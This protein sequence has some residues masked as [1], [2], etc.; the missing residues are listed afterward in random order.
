MANFDKPHIDISDR[1]KTRNYQA[2]RENRGGGSAPRIREQHGARLQQQLAAAYQAAQNATPN[3]TGIEVSGVLIEVELQ[4]GAK[5]DLLDRKSDGIRAGAVHSDGQ[6]ASTIGLLVPEGAKAV[7]E[8]ILQDYRSGPLTP[9]R[10]IPQADK[11]EPIEAIRQAR[12]ETFWTDELSALPQNPQDQ[13]WWEVWCIK[14]KQEDVRSA[15]ARLG[16]HV[17]DQEQWLTFPEAIVIPI[18]ATRAAIELLLFASL[19]VTELRR[20]S[21]TPAFFL[22]EN[23]EEQLDWSQDFADRITWPDGNAPAV[24]LLDTGVNRGH[25]LIEPA[26]AV[27]DLAAV[28]AEWGT[29][30]DRRGHGTGMAGLALHSDLVSALSDGRTVQLTH[31]L[32]SVKILP[33]N[34]FDPTDP[35]NYGTITQTAT[36][37][38]ELLAPE[39]KRVFC[40]SVTN[41]DVSGSRATTWSAAIDQAAV[42]KMIGDDEDAPRRLFVV[43]AGNTIPHLERHRIQDA[44]DSPIEDPAQAWNALT[45]G[46]Y[47]E[48]T[49]IAEETH[50]GWSAFSGV[51]EL[52]PHTRTSVTWPGSKSPFKPEIVMEAGNR[53]V[54]PSGRE[55]HCVESLQMLTTGTNETTHPLVNFAATSAAA[56]QAARL[57]A[58]LSARYPDLWPETIRA[59]IIHS[60]EWTPW[61]KGKLAVASKSEAASLIRQFGYGV[62]SFERAAASAE[63]HLA[64][65][66][67]NAITPFKLQ[68]DRKF[69]DCHFYRLPWPTDVLEQLGDRQVRLKVTLSYFI[70]PN[71]GASAAIDPQR[72]QSFG[73]RFDLK[74]RR[75]RMNEFLLRANPMERDDPLSR[76]ATEPDD[77]WKF[78]EKNISAGSVH[79][80]E[81]SG[82]A[83]YLAARDA[84]CIRPV[85]GWWR[86]R[87]SAEE[88]RRSTRYSLIIT[89]SAPD[90]EIDL[91]TPIMTSV[92]NVAD[93]E[94]N[95][96][97]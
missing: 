69:R 66:A 31:R 40:L 53:A 36:A 67:Q 39:R 20:A 29:A 52:S 5:P 89:L 1:V 87:G 41:E 21:A 18:Y 35:R 4:R 22:N 60:A 84:I 97:D 24:C 51:G 82:P 10:N 17:V 62:P 32:E 65:I 95:F 77:G 54:S 68:G 33:P 79:C 94:I 70:E 59:L 58:M 38:G 45:V 30:D 80:D 27:N 74:R 3:A 78:G 16:S 46:G 91:Y 43:S 12:L 48:K 64:L 73:L 23:A 15:A 83:A 56:A 44:S 42:G 2:P 37:L 75:E 50:R 13:I 14:G 25:I 63:N 93:V 49:V 34:G 19:A 57:A 7:L 26:L 81:W 85:M 76:V 71:P 96:R 55:V 72:Y 88:C 11:V 90:I 92:E 86:N 9:K 28:R 6:G 47:T 8:Q 61:M